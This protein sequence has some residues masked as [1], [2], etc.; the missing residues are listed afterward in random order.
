MV[1]GV[2]K[3]AAAR[4]R[5]LAVVFP[6]EPTDRT[7]SAPATWLSDPLLADASACAGS[8]VRRVLTGR[9]VL[10]AAVVQ[11]ALVA[12][13]LVGF[14]RLLA[15]GVSPCLVVGVGAGEI[16][17]WAAS[18]AIGDHDALR[19]AALR[20]AAVELASL[21]HPA[22]RRSSPGGWNSIAMAPAREV[23]AA[24][25]AAAPRMLRH[26]PQVESVGG[27]VL[28][29]DEAPDLGLQLV[30]PPAWRSILD[31]FL[32]H[33]VTD[34]AVLPPGRTARNVVQDALGATSVH[35]AEGD[36]DLDALARALAPKQEEA[37]TG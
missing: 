16:A 36:R 20:G 8:D 33:G 10:G 28:A 23:I 4:S 26:V 27:A 11:P 9:A 24:A 7:L 21:V 25:A 35:T 19:L 5:R 6:A 12:L 14:R 32:R 2:R 13:Q 1:S 18:G 29:D 30:E 3:T 31:A 37:K 34:V 17:A 15:C 22:T